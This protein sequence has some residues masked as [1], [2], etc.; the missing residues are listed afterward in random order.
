MRAAADAGEARYGVPADLTLAVAWA[1][2]RW[3]LPERDADDHEHATATLGIGGLRNGVALDHVLAEL[4]VR[5]EDVAH[6]AV[7]GTFVTAAVLR[8]LADERGDA[9]AELTGWRGTLAD[10]AQ[11]DER[12]GRAHADYLL[13]ILRV[14]LEADA[15]GG[16]HIVLS[17]RPIAADTELDAALA[18]GGAEYGGATWS[19]ASSSN[20]TAGRGGHSIRYIVIHDTEGSYSGAISWFRNPSSSVSAHYVIRSSDGAITQMVSEGNSGWHAGNWTYNQESI[21]IEHEGFYREPERWY[22]EAMYA[23]SATL[24]RHLCNKYGIPIDRSHII[25]HSEV[26]GASHVD[27]GP[28]WNWAHY[29]DLVRGTPAR[30]AYDATAA[31]ISVPA[32]MTSG[33]REVAYVELANTGSATWSI[34]TTR[35]GTSA[36]QDHES[37]FFDLENWMSPSRASGADHSYATGSTGRFTFMVHAPEVTTDTTITDTFRLVQEGVTWFGPDVTLSVVIHPRAAVDGDGDGSIGDDC[38]DTDPARHPGATDVCGN[39]IDEDC[40]GSDATCPAE[41][42]AGNA[43]RPDAGV[44]ERDAGPFGMSRREPSGCSCRMSQRGG[45]PAVLPLLGALA[46]ACFRRRPHR[47]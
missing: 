13:S 1:E 21:G 38:D 37:P 33:D 20:Y 32:E 23:S 8:A 34:D 22:T 35:I 40:D 6:D 28:G 18:Y 11:L 2:T 36:P 10:Y 45:S 25:A 44:T 31:S 7:L 9:P 17:A 14:G 15:I 41:T 43:A 24:V 27:P 16:E 12:M 29:M 3:S 19:A 42:D 39:A 5:E 30:P 4:D 47:A 26:P 46:I